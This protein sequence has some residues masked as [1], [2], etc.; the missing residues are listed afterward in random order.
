MFEWGGHP[1]LGRSD[2]VIEVLPRFRSARL[3]PLR[4]MR[5]LVNDAL[6]GLDIEFAKIYS[7]IG[8]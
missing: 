1:L 3:H 4:K 7:P 5:P 8:R 2:E 6:I